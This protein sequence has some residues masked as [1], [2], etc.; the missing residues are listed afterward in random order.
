MPRQ[1]PDSHARDHKDETLTGND[2]REWTSLPD[3]NGVYHWKPASSG[4]RTTESRPIRARKSSTKAPVIKAP[5]VKSSGNMRLMLCEPSTLFFGRRA[6]K[7]KA[8]VEVPVKLVETAPKSFSGKGNN[9]Y[10]FGK[11]PL[12]ADLAK[13]T[14]VASIGN[15][16]AQVGLIDVDRAI[17][18]DYLGDLLEWFYSG[19]KRWLWYNPAIL[20][21]VQQILPWIVFL[22]DTNGG[23]VGAD[24]WVRKEGDKVVSMIVDNF[25]FFP[26]ES[27]D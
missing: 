21:R 23:D 9:A 8:H 3:K 15:D 18:V 2:G 25:Y 19:Q 10:V 22:G 12:K 27:E 7:Y 17:P 16:V 5:A 6:P 11:I 20:T 24:L 26:Q 4:S 14:R 1:S 13:Y